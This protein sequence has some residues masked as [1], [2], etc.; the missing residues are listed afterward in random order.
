MVMRRL[1]NTLVVACALQ[2]A[3]IPALEAASLSEKVK[4]AQ[5]KSAKLNINTATQV[6]LQALP[7]IGAKKADAIIDYRSSIGKFTSVAQLRNVKG[8]GD[9]M[10]IKLTAVAEAK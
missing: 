4:A 7:G 3:S 10:L 6:E 1:L 9:K 8:I 5:T 2:L